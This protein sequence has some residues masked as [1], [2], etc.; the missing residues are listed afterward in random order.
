MHFLLVIVATTVALFWDEALI[1]IISVLTQRKLSAVLLILWL[2]SSGILAGILISLHVPTEYRVITMI[3]I[4]IAI[5][6]N[7]NNY[8]TK[9][10]HDY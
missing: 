6:F 1:T 10:K 2:V 8:H 3:M 7:L 4:T 9:E 5:I